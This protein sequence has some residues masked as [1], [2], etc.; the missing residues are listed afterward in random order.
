VLTI[1]GT[2]VSIFDQPPFVPQAVSLTGRAMFADARKSVAFGG[3]SKTVVRADKDT[4][5]ALL[6]S[7]SYVDPT[8][9]GARTPAEQRAIE[10]RSLPWAASSPSTA[11]TR[12]P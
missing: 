5:A 2:K 12:S 8:L 7:Q 1:R 9:A 6:I 11:T 3:K 4:S 10:Q